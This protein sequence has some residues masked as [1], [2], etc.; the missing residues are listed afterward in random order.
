MSKRLIIAYI[1]HGSYK[2]YSQWIYIYDWNYR[3]KF[4]SFT[5]VTEELKTDTPH[6]KSTPL[7]ANFYFAN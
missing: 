3:E 7:E 4:E 1:Y 6:R 2:I 5:N